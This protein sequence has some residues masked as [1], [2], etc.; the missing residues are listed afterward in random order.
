MPPKKEPLP[1]PTP[2]KDPYTPWDNAF[3]V[4]INT[5]TNL[6][7]LGNAL[8]NVW[9]YLVAHSGEFFYGYPGSSVLEVKQ[10]HQ[11]EVGKKYHKIHLHGTWIVKS[12]GIAMMDFY[13]VNEFINQNLRQVEGF[14]RANFQAKLIKNYNQAR[15][16]R[17]YI[18]KE[19][20][21]EQ[22]EEE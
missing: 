8:K 6:P 2:G 16:I 12:T 9:R 5:N 20:P 17:E 7:G 22:E 18:E 3:L 21:V 11:I 14:K 4:T 10:H 1:R 19:M 15:L 13:K